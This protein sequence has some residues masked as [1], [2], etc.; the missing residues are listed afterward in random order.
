MIPG[1]H[2]CL[3]CPLCCASVSTLPKAA[4]DNTQTAKFQVTRT[5]HT[6]LNVNLGYD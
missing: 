1:T 3:D 6:R 4:G 5:L 2:D